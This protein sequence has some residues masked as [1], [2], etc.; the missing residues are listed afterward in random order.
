MVG[1]FFSSTGIVLHFLSWMSLLQ[2][3]CTLM[4]QACLAVVLLHLWPSGSRWSGSITVRGW[5]F[6]PGI[7]LGGHDSRGVVWGHT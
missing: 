6:G 2:L 4:R 5:N 3:M 1:L 7:G